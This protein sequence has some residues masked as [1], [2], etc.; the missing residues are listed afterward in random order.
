MLRL[1]LAV[2]AVFLLLSSQ[3]FGEV[4]VGDSTTRVATFELQIEKLHNVIQGTHTVVDVVVNHGSE[5][6]DG[7]DLLI[8]YDASALTFA[9]ASEGNIYDCGWEYFSYRDLTGGSYGAGCPSGLVRIVG[10]AETNNG[11]HHPDQN[12]ADTLSHPYSLMILDFLITDDRTL[13]CMYVPIRFIW[14]DCGDNSLA[15]STDDDPFAAIQG[16]SRHVWQ[17]G[18]DPMINISDSTTGFPTLTGVQEECLEGGGEN[19]PAP[20]PFVDFINGGIDII[21][22]DSID[23]R[24]DI[25]LNAE[26]NEIADAVLLSNYFVHGLSVFMVNVAGQIA[27]SDT[28]ADGVALTVADLVY[29]IRVIIGDAQPYSKLNPV[30]ATVSHQDRVVAVDTRLGAAWLILEGN[31][32]P[33]LLADEMDMAYKFDGTNTRVLISSTNR[34]AGFEGPFLTT[35]SDVLRIEMAT[36]DGAPVVFKPLPVAYTLESNYPNP[37]NPTTRLAFTLPVASNYSFTIFNI[38]GQ[39]VERINGHAQPGRHEVSWDASAEASGVYFYRFEAGDF[40]ATK[41][42]MLLK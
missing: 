19:K 30:A 6:I 31:A 39:V 7:F 9:S 14:M 4:P 42:M 37:F 38:G 40:S 10:I 36:Y 5:Q 15:Y 3:S 1:P 33:T 16:V 24:G 21:C 25:N 26:P 28:N 41:K 12:C 27:A 17:Y 22:S 23:D 18:L 34:G 20:I 32:T 8:S 35:N 11:G 29:L 2:A 13:E